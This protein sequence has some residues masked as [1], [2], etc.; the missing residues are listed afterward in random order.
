MLRL[1]R[2][3]AQIKEYMGAANLYRRALAIARERRIVLGEQQALLNLGI[4]YELWGDL[5]R[6]IDYYEQHL[7]VSEAA[8]DDDAQMLILLELGNRYHRIKQLPRA[9]QTYEAYLA[10]AEGKND[11]SGKGQAFTRLGDLARDWGKAKEAITHYKEALGLAEEHGTK[12]AQASILSNLGLAYQETSDIGRT[13]LALRYAERAI[14][15]AEEARSAK[16]LAFAHY[17]L[18]LLLRRQKKWDKAKT[19]IEEA[20]Q[21]FG[22][23][24]NM[25]MMQRSRRMTERLAE[26]R[27]SSGFLS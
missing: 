26:E 12:A 7:A 13:W 16:S 5:G 19:H 10:L 11:L 23:I 3:N 18:G 14:G 17:K 1:G 21:L 6:A 24:G 20:R 9:K 25:T 4:V 2:A 22:A 27:A 15:V 8:N